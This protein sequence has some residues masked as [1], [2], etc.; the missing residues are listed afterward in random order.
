MLTKEKKEFIMDGVMWL[1]FTLTTFCGGGV[2]IIIK[3]TQG[4]DSVIIGCFL[5]VIGLVISGNIIYTM[6]KW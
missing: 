2:A 4:I 1:L 3:G 5:V 6:V